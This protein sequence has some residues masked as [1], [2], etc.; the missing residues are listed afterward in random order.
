M[1]KHISTGQIRELLDIDR[2]RGGI[3]PEFQE[4]ISR[5][6]SGGVGMKN[7]DPRAVQ[8]KVLWDKGFGR[9]SGCRSFQDYLATIPEIP[10]ELV[11]DDPRFPLLVLVDDR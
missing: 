10:P 4:L 2:A 6:T 9:E 5:L 7:D 11:D 1:G 3:G 8:A